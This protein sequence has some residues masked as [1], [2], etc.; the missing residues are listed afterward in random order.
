MQFGGKYL[1]EASRDRVWAALND[2]SVLRQ[3]IPG[4]TR[5]DWVSGT[6]LEADVAV[7]LGFVRPV[8]SGELELFDIDPAVRYTLSGRGK[9]GVLGL[10]HGD[11][12]IA[13][14]DSGSGT[15]LIFTATGGASGRIMNLG[16]SLLGRSAQNIIDRFFE[17]IGAAMGA[18]VTPLHDGGE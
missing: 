3:A 8:F 13:L 12:D 15:E 11:A 10:A 16:K 7:N 9:G 17:R 1:F 6:R 2:T 5:I 14:A 4:C 18:N